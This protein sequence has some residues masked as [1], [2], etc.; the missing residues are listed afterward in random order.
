MK[1]EVKDQTTK[2]LLAAFGFVAGLAWNDAVKAL[3]ESVFPLAG[4]GVWAKFLYA[5]LVTL[6]VVLVGKYILKSEEDK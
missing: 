4:D 6:A 3:I 5:V 2:Y 1:S